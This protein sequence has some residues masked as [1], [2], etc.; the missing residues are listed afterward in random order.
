MAGSRSAWSIGSPE[1]AFQDEAGTYGQKTACRPHG[2]CPLFHLY[3][4]VGEKQS[5]DLKQRTRCDQVCVRHGVCF[6]TT[7]YSGHKF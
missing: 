2:V 3:P 1:G 5:A 7:Q 4:V 6:K